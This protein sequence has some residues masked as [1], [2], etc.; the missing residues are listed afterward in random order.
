MN[1]LRPLIATFHEH[2]DAGIVSPKILYQHDPGIIYCAGG[3]LSILLCGGVARYQGKNT[4]Y[5]GNID[6]EITL[7]EGCCFLV[8]R[9]VFETVGL[10]DEKF[11][12]YFEDVEFS[13]RIRKEYK[14][15]YNAH[16]I[17]YHKCGAGLKWESFSTLYYYY[18]TRNRFLVFKE[19]FFLYKLYV[20]LFSTANTLAKTLV[21][22]M[23]MIRYKN[24]REHIYK[25]LLSLWKGYKD[26][27]ALFF[28]NIQ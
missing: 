20:L 22:I 16:S 14:I 27:E 1:S 9:K 10:M 6:R 13:E 12:M 8:K 5:F 15:H 7:A 28:N 2:P 24:K 23:T 17:V 21:L 11:F 3:E 19:Y 4:E 25:S 26:G 18:Y